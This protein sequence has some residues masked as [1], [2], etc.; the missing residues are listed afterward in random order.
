MPQS[1][2]GPYVQRTYRKDIM[3]NN[4]VTKNHACARPPTPRGNKSNL[5]KQEV[6]RGAMVSAAGHENLNACL[7][8]GG[9]I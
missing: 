9:H 4:G 2:M 5:N 7:Y 3:R 8:I 1:T 6:A